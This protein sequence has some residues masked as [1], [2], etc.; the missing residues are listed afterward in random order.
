MHHSRVRPR[1]VGSV[2][3]LHVAEPLAVPETVLPLVVLYP[4]LEQ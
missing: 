4:L 3:Y 2:R 1:L